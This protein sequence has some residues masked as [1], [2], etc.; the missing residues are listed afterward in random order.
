MSKIK[1]WRDRVPKETTSFDYPR[2]C[3][4]AADAEINELRAKLAAL[5]GQEPVA[6][7]I[8]KAEQ[9]CLSSKDGSRPFAKAWEP[10]FPAAGAREPALMEA[11]RAIQNC[12]LAVPNGKFKR[13]MDDW[14]TAK[15]LDNAGAREA[16]P[17]TEAESIAGYEIAVDML[18]PQCVWLAAVRWA[19]AHYGI[20][21]ARE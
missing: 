1:T 18:T 20:K 19:E 11:Y 3:R 16:Q 6:W 5:E 9:F 15:L 14:L 2:A 13:E 7:W 12:L 17:M 10:L 8:P 4:E 21:G